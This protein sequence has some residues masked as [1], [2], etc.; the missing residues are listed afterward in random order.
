M[1]EIAIPNPSKQLE[2]CTVWQIWRAYEIFHA[3]WPTVW[4]AAVR[5]RELDE[6]C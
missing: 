6:L 3:L 4:R 1:N 5:R 2:T